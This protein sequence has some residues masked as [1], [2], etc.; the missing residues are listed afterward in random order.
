M[1]T[2]ISSREFNQNISQARHMAEAGPVIITDRG[3]PKQVLLSIEEYHR[4][5]GQKASIIDALKMD[6]ADAIDFDMPTFD[7]NLMK[8][9]DIDG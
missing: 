9:H 6:E 2:T 1:T 3:T 7:N 8:P 4:L 5:T